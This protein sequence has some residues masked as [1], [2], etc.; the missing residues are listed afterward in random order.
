MTALTAIGTHVPGAR[1]PIEDLADRF[2]LTAMQTKVF[3]RYHKLGEVSRD[4]GGSLLDLLRGALDDLD[5]LK[6]N[7]ERVRYVI[8]AR[9]PALMSLLG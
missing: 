7:E 2:G 5:A 9:T 1:V 8:H 3:R 4:P 6:G